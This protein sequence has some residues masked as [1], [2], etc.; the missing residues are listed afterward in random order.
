ML[1]QSCGKNEAVFHYK[2]SINGN[3]TEQHLCR[4]CAAALGAEGVS[5]VP[6]DFFGSMLTDIFAPVLPG[7]G[8]KHGAAAVCPQCGSTARDIAGRGKIGCAKCWDVFSDMLLPHVR[9]I[10]G[11]VRH[12]GKIPGSAAAGLRTRHELE[13]LKAQLKTAVDAQEYE[14]AAVLRDRIKALEEGEN[15]A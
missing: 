4:D 6:Q 7:G 10:H 14:R 8:V 9:R 1:C 2:S 3:V 11:N 13:E 15:N 12:A 5:A